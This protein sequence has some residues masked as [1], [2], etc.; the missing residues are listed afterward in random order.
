MML[1]TFPI[2]P[3]GPGPSAFQLDFGA[4]PSCRLCFRGKRPPQIRFLVLEACRD[5]AK[6]SRSR[7]VDNSLH[8]MRADQENYEGRRYYVWRAQDMHDGEGETRPEIGNF[9]DS[10]ERAA[11]KGA[12]EVVRL[13]SRPLKARYVCSS[14]PFSSLR[15]PQSIAKVAFII[16]IVTDLLGS[17]SCRLQV[18]TGVMI[19]FDISFN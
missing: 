12:T 18:R 13:D 4:V 7:A 8:S 14:V 5:W 11:F 6:S 19:I 10:A 2:Q 1:S 15:C 16:K 9:A 3:C 17:V